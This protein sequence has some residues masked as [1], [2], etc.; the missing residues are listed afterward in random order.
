MKKLLSVVLA[1]LIVVPSV[2]GVNQTRNNQTIL[3]GVRAK[4]FD[5]D[6]FNN[7]V[8]EVIC[9]YNYEMKGLQNDF[10]N[11]TIPPHLARQIVHLYEGKMGECNW[12]FKWL[13]NIE[14]VGFFIG[15]ALVATIV[16]ALTVVVLK[17]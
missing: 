13:P 17:T 15:G 4:D 9:A 10:V 3:S 2:F 14:R 6:S 1:S 12:R 8:N 5:N 11:S 16:G 7:C